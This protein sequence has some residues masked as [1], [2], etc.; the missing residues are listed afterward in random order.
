MLPPMV[1]TLRTWRPAKR[2]ISSPI[3]GHGAASG[4]SASL[5]RHRRADVE[6]RVALDDALQRVDL[7]E[8]HEHVE[9]AMLL[10]DLQ[11]EIGGAGDEDRIGRSGEQVVEL[12]QGSRRMPASCAG[13]VGETGRP[14]E[15]TQR[16]C[17]R[18]G[19]AREGI[20]CAAQA[21]LLG[22]VE[23][24]AIAG[25]AAQIAAQRPHR[26]LAR[27]RRVIVAVGEQAH[28]EARRAE[29]ALR[30]VMIDHRLLH[31]MQRAVRRLQALDRDQLA[32]VERRDRL[33]AGID[34]AMD[35]P[36]TVA[37]LRDDHGA[38]AAIALRAALL[39]AAAPL[40]AAQP[41]E[42][43]RVRIDPVDLAHAP[44][45]QKTD[46][47][48]RTEPRPMILEHQRRD[49]ARRGR[50]RLSS[51]DGRGDRISAPRA[52]DRAG[53]AGR[54]RRCRRRIGVRARRLGCASRHV[55]GRGAAR[56]D[57]V[58][59]GAGG[60]AGD[61][62]V[63]WPAARSVVM[64]GVNYA[65]ETDPMALLARRERGIVSAYAQRRDYHDVIKSRL[66]RLGRWMVD[67]LGGEVKVFV[68]T[69]PV[70]EK[71]LAAAA[72][73][74]WQGKHTNLVSREFGSWLFLG[75]V[76][77]TLELEPDVPHED[78]CGACTR[79]LDVCPTQAF[80]APYQL[81]ARR[82]IAYL[83]IEHKGHIAEEFRAAIGNRVFG[84]DDCL[85][86]CPWN[87]FAQAARDQQLAVRPVLDAPALAELAG[88]DDAAFRAMFAGTPVKRTGRDRLVRNVMIAIGNTG[89][90]ALV[91]VVE[92]RLDD[93]SA[94]VRAM[95]VWALARLVD[96]PRFAALRAHHLAR[97][98][99]DAVIAEWRRDVSD[100]T[101]GGA[102]SA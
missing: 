58:V 50:T 57:G 6:M 15:R 38:G 73:I 16:P 99:D 43:G 62:R 12:G 35:E 52:G 98:G 68:D 65:P 70:M 86:V 53:Q 20:G 30:A 34:R 60:A 63:L 67:T 46:A 83:T 45:E 33:D 22:G 100:A 61:P 25:T 75:A 29:A 85:A 90:P 76:F 92:A 42:H 5:Q 51:G 95:A 27:C 1:A 24:G 19:V 54:V 91:P 80:P 71:P 21:D 28:H 36:A 18:V 48:H 87:K 49:R 47:G 10:G 2:A 3:A 37:R 26:R 102:P 13:R 89:A 4:P 93:A 32:P 39:G 56:R 11:A 94:L 64:L 8:L 77:T 96:A 7:P 40:G 9:A 23:D 66:K 79:C 78:H 84:C 17:R 74:G 44:I 82:C 101:R 72:G 81:D 59:G 55:P 31:G 97:E 88:L 41:F 69:A 14:R